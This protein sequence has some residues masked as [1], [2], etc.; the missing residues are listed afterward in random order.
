MI[1]IQYFTIQSQYTA[2]KYVLLRLDCLF[3]FNT[4]QFACTITSYIKVNF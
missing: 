4:T 2:V 3:R 1:N